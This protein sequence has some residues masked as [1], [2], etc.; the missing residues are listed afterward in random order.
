MIA[1]AWALVLALALQGKAPQNAGTVWLAGAGTTPP[2]SQRSALLLVAAPADS[3]APLDARLWGGAAD[4]GILD[5][6]A[7]FAPLPPA[8]LER[9]RRARRVLLGPGDL[10]Q[11]RAVLWHQTRP[12][13]LA[14]AL[15]EAWTDGAEIAARGAGA[16]LLGETHLEVDAD[17]RARGATVVRPGLALCQ[18]V[19]LDGSARGVQLRSLAESVLAREVRV[20]LWLPERGG[21]RWEPR[22][23][24][25]VG[26]GEEAGLAFDARAARHAA[27]RVERVLVEWIDAGSTGL[28]RDP[29]RLG[30]AG[31]A[32]QV[33]AR[34]AVDPWDPD[35][36]RVAPQA[37][38]TR[39]GAGER[40]QVQLVRLPQEQGL[41][42]AAWMSFAP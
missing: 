41:A 42:A 34:A 16:L 39:L 5:V 26:F 21:L 17:E 33:D 15:H 36:W 29:L 18:G 30:P 37:A 8:A 27:E 22:T 10:D 1:S 24:R 40:G 13:A 35:R 9:V 3:P 7:E 38:S 2:A 11:W 28:A 25:W 32:G 31:A 14:R 6:R 19:T 12:S 4:S 23:A 20:A